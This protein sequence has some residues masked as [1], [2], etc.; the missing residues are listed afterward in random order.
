MCM[1]EAEVWL[2]K[3]L[4]FCTHVW[5]CFG[6]FSSDVERR[7]I[8][9]Q[10]Q[11]ENIVI[12]L[13]KFWMRIKYPTECTDKN[14]ENTQRA[15]IELRL[16]WSYSYHGFEQCTYSFWIWYLPSNLMT[17]KNEPKTSDQLSMHFKRIMN[18]YFDVFNVTWKSS[19]TSSS[20]IHL[21]LNALM[22][23][24]L[25]SIVH[26]SQIK[27]MWEFCRKKSFNKD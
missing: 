2:S 13:E 4:N 10:N 16:E 22:F 6:R 18:E 12:N 17:A 9:T 5:L 25:I 15:F 21:W 8:L 14:A 20:Y 11:H 26:N 23:Q 27:V 3:M 19:N 24:R 1:F 7:C